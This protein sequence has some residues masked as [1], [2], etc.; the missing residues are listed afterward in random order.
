LGIQ[1][2]LMRADAGLRGFRASP[3]LQWLVSPLLALVLGLRRFPAKA[4]YLID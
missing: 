1:A 2:D 3:L 4:V